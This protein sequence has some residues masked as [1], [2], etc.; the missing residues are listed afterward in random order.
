MLPHRVVGWV[1]EGLCDGFIP[2]GTKSQ[3][4]RSQETKRVGGWVVLRNQVE[5]GQGGGERVVAAVNN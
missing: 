2:K 1:K 4:G 5:G 3:G